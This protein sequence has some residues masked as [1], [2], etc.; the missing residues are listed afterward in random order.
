MY[1]EMK[2]TIVEKLRSKRKNHIALSYTQKILRL[3]KRRYFPS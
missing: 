2:N 3:T 1:F